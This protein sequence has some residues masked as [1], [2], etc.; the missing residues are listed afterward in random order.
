MVLQF[1]ISEFLDFGGGISE[2]LIPGGG[3]CDGGLPDVAGSSVRGPKTSR[4]LFVA[5]SASKA[6]PFRP[7]EDH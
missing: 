6:S 1:W 3:N 7:R 2:L 5:R 4:G